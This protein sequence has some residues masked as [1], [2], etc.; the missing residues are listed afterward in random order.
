[1]PVTG[2]GDIVPGLATVALLNLS[3][4]AQTERVSALCLVQVLNNFMVFDNILDPWI[5]SDD[6]IPS[7]LLHNT[8]QKLAECRGDLNRKTGKRSGGQYLVTWTRESASSSRK[9]RH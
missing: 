4:S 2:S 6:L 8:K 1:M 9:G 5:G 3:S 7:W